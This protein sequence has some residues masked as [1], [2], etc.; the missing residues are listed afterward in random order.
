M[1]D[2]NFQEKSAWGTLIAL[3]VLGALYFT[4]VANLWRADALK[5]EA[6]FGL[7]VG[8]TVLLVI[9]LT[10]YHIVI[11]SLGRTDP[12][13]ERDRLIRRRA[14]HESGLVLGFAVIFVVIEIVVGGTLGRGLLFSLASSPARISIALI[15][16]IWLSTVIELGLT[17]RY[18]RRGP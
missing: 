16:A 13:D 6:V 5:I 10:A 7:G 11:A 1:T 17:L 15:A 12:D 8:F 18:Y 2:L 14:G 4:S 9:V 3:L